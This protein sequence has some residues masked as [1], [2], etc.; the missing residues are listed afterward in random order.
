MQNF[1]RH[2]FSVFIKNQVIYLIQLL[3]YEYLCKQSTQR[4]CKYISVVRKI[5]YGTI[6][7]NLNLCTH[8]TVKYRIYAFITQKIMKYSFEK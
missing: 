5:L 3:I 8:S 1:L 2:F 6:S 4:T 7:K